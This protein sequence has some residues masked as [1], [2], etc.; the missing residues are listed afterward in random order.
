MALKT[1]S[2]LVIQPPNQGTATNS[3]ELRP[4]KPLEPIGSPWPFIFAGLVF[5]IILGVLIWKWWNKK[6]TLVTKSGVVIPPHRRA[7]DRLN[8]ALQLLADP[9]TFCTV[10]SEAIRIY[11]EERFSLHAPDR[12]TEEFL[13][14]LHKT[15]LINELQKEFLE[16]FLRRCDMVKFA[17]HEPTEPELLELLESALRLV[18][19]T[20]S[21]EI[22]PTTQAES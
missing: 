20:Q 8:R 6:R 1:N 9:Y 15:N 19:E 18:D 13:H 4:A 17:Q 5:S 16:D 11:L 7:K 3:M 21:V 2:A 10:V 12:T 22:N 14:E